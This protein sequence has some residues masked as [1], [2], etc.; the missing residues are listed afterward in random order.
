MELEGRGSVWRAVFGGQWER[1]SDRRQGKGWGPRTVRAGSPLPGS[2]KERAL[3]PTAR[4][5]PPS[6]M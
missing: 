3:T 6:Q 2:G 1:P 4:V 5:S